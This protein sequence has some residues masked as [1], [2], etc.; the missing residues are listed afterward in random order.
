M[1]SEIKKSIL[2]DINDVFTK[3]NINEPVI[4]EKPKDRKLADY[5]IPCF[6]YAK[7]MHMNPNEVANKI[8]ENIE[9]EII[10]KTEIVNGYLNLFLNKKNV[11]Q[12]VIK[13]ILNNNEHYGDLALGNG[14][15]IV[16]DYSAPNIAKPFGVGHLRSTVI[17]N[18]LKKIYNK[19]GYGTIGINYIGDYGTQFGKLLYAY[20]TWGNENEVKSNP[21]EEL[22]KLYVKF[23][24]EARLNPA[25]ED[26]GRKYFKKIEDKDNEALALWQWIRDESLKEF[27]KTYKLLDINDFDSYEGEAF[28]ADKTEPVINELKA[29]ELL[30]KDEGAMIVKLGDDIA[31]ALITKSD[32]TSLYIT[33]ELASIFDRKNR[34]HFD[35]ILYVV[36]N[37]QTLH[38][39]Q[40]KRLITKMGYTWASD[41]HHINFGMI[42]QDGKKMSTRNGKTVNLHEVLEESISLANK[43]IAEKN[44]DLENKEETSKIIGVGAVIFNDLKNYRTGDVEFNLD[45]ILKFEGETGPYIQYTYVRINSMLENMK[46]IDINI[47]NICIN[48]YIW[49]II[50]KLLVFEEV[51]IQAGANYD[52]SQIAK[53]MLDLAQDYNKFYA[54]ERII[55]ESLEESEFKLQLS[56]ATALL[57]K[58]GMSLLG[59]K[60]PIKM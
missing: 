1:I 12:K 2:T 34:Y 28:Y 26:E 7:V 36:G 49:N 17:G 5:S 30:E 11:T 55:T 25:L 42:L 31:P 35:Q 6:S 52:P 43:Y 58:E 59:I 18:S 40:V 19:L 8:N 33:R 27:M 60:M 51:L 21:I 54:N 22:R 24:E 16:I 4:L 32:G 56:K 48:E 23:H 20:K 9:S 38:F 15:T 57:L 13:Q 41:I 29:K 37:E 46:N 50:M 44:P 47:N 39:N 3:L 53:Y 10:E 14:K 45:D